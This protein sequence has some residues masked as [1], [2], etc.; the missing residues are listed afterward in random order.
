MA[1]TYMGSIIVQNGQQAIGPGETGWDI[2][3]RGPWIDRGP[4]GMEFAGL[5]S[6]IGL[7]LNA[8]SRRRRDPRRTTHFSMQPC[9]G[10]PEM[11]RNNS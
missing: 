2:T 4:A 10:G 8:R 1:I 7:S 11:P 5:T 9:T 6:P 3:N